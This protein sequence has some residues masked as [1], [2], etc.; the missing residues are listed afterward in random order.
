MKTAAEDDVESDDDVAPT[1]K[2]TLKK[3]SYFLAV[4]DS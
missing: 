4:E 3:N 2:A 1:S